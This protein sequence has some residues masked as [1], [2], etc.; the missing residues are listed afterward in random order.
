MRHGNA[1]NRLEKLK[2][3]LKDLVYTNTLSLLL[4]YSL[5]KSPYQPSFEQ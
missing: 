4:P 5:D 3:T 2:K 1:D